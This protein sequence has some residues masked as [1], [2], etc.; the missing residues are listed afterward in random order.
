MPQ[1]GYATHNF[2]AILLEHAATVLDAE[3]DVGDVAYWDNLTIRSWDDDPFQFADDFGVT[4]SRCGRQW[5][6]DMGDIFGIRL[7]QDMTC[8]WSL[9]LL[10]HSR[11]LGQLHSRLPQSFRIEIDLVVGEEATDGSDFCHSG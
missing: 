3:M 11:D 10:E 6:I 8:H 5:R 1:H 4:Q 7:V 2:A 9:H